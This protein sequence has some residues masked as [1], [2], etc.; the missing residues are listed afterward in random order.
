MHAC[1]SACFVEDSIKTT[2]FYTLWQSCGI[3]NLPGTRAKVYRDAHSNIQVLFCIVE[4]PKNL[5]M[6]E[7]PD[8][9]L[10]EGN[11]ISVDGLCQSE[12]GYPKSQFIYCMLYPTSYI[13]KKC[14]NILLYTTL[15]IM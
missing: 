12:G 4:P 10:I 2:K 14:L 7:I 5:T 1:L 8:D 11:T 3:S 6:G 15:T 13:I 9:S